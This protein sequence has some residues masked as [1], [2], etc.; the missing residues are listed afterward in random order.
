MPADIRSFFGGKPASTPIRSREAPKEEESKK[1]RGT[2]EP[3]FLWYLCVLN[4]HRQSK[5]R[6]RQ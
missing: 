4:P 2:L 6:R 1:K 5:S 3:D